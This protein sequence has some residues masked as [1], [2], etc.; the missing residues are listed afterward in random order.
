MPYTEKYRPK[1]LKD[2][3][4]H[5]QHLIFL[6]NWSKEWENG[7]PKVRA[8]IF[9]GPPGIGKT[10]IAHALA[11]EI[12]WEVIE[13]NASDTRTAGAIQRIAGS[14]SKS[15]S[16]DSTYSRKLI[17]LDEADNLHGNS[18]R[19]GGRAIINL[20]K[21]TL[22]PV[23]LIVNNF[24]KL[25]ASLRS[26]SLCKSLQFKN[27]NDIDVTKAL[28]Y[29][30]DNENIE[31]EN[32]VV[33]H[34][35]KNSSGDVRAA[36]N[37]LE[38]ICK[39]KTNVSIDDIT[40]TENDKNQRNISET[41]FTFVDKVFKEKDIKKVLEIS[42]NID[43]NPE[44]TIHWLDEN[45]PLAYKDTNE[46]YEAYDLLSKADIFFGRV[47]KRQ[48]Y[49]LWKYANTLIC[50]IGSI[51]KTNSGF[52]RYS[53]PK[54]FS[55]LKQ[56]KP[57]RNIKK[58]I[59]LKIGNVC[60]ISIKKVLSDML[61]FIKELMQND[62]YSILV[63]YEL[64]FTKDEIAYLLGCKSNSEKVT[65]IIDVIQKL[66]E[67]N[68]EMDGIDKVITNNKKDAKDKVENKVQM[69]LMDF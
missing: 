61:W 19:G 51:G 4:G 43:E 32:K 11:N 34:I 64:D 46:L 40:N 30:C 10:T 59:A 20:I 1:I 24:Y 35:V 47:H 69:Q 60:H 56:S 8:L 5:Q 65:T 54:Y 39:G 38:S 37:D 44:S 26:S 9:Y 18:D 42:N 17:I 12:K 50:G 21:E 48:N 25:D 15:M 58:S 6:S 13:L 7:I 29:I 45:I 67:D 68:V 41:V 14:A 3:V 55:K 52:V 27:V 53:P 49:S 33:K 16:L 63:T 31:I 62:E 28:I 66:K 57:N 36:V 22:Q 2:V 23:I